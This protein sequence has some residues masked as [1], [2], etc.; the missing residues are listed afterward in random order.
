MPIGG[1]L[2]GE[3]R[4]GERE[5]DGATMINSDI[6]RINEKIDSMHLSRNPS[7]MM[8]S[9]REYERRIDNEKI[10]RED[11]G[12]V[13]RMDHSYRLTESDYVDRPLVPMRSPMRSPL[14]SPAL[15][16]GMEMNL[17]RGNAFNEQY[18]PTEEK[19]GWV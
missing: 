5:M 1:E 7:M 6:H 15:P 3:Q 13:K 19:S 2:D 4:R 12:M 16:P 8:N 17:P 18:Y 9:R 10:K 11:V 14:R